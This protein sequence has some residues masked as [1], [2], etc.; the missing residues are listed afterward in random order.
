MSTELK[1]HIRKECTINGVSN[2]IFNAL[3]AWL[4]LRGGA[5]LSLGGDR[6]FAVDLVAT[7]F[8]L[9]FIVTLI[10]IPLNQRQLRKQAVSAIKLNPDKWLENCLG[11]F[12]KG[13]F[14]RA[15][16]FGLIG[17]LVLAPLTILP[18][19]LLGI[20]QFTPANYAIFKGLWAGTIAALLAVPMILLALETKHN[21]DI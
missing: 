19:W 18:L 20:D 21:S 10:I 13:L 11:R 7:G 2:V 16:W 5:D 17:M 4:M 12:P 15:V 8:I 3:I 1:H 14:L 9:P 6:G